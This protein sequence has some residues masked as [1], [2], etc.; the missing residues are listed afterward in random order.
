MPAVAPTSAAGL[1]MAGSSVALWN[2][3]ASVELSAA[4]RLRDT[5]QGQRATSDILDGI[6]FEIEVDFISVWCPTY[7]EEKGMACKKKK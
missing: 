5:K 7:L 3:A 1:A 4:D 2:A 6:E